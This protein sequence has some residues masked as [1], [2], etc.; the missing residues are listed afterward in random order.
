MDQREGRA[1]GIEWVKCDLTDSVAV[2]GVLREAAPD[3]IIHLAGV[4]QGDDLHAYFAANVAAAGHLL[5]AAAGLAQA[6]RV[7]VVGSAA[8]YGVTSLERVGVDETQPLLAR[9][10]YGLSKT[11]QEKWSL[12]YVVRQL[13]PVVAVRPFNIIGPGQAPSLVPAA[14][15]HQIADVVDGKARDV[16][17]GILS[18]ERDFVDAR[19]VAAALWALMEAGSG[20]DGEVFNIASGEAVKISDMLNACIRLSGRDIVVRQNPLRMRGGDVQT[21]VGDAAKLRRLTGWQPRIPWRQSLADM[22]QAIR[23]RRDAGGN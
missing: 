21:V 20:A 19:D 1:D 2:A 3:G 18:T 9:T 15:L 12:L 6:P 8:Q 11:L 5:A 13:L 4:S 23:N 10:P 14:F 16:S 17:V 22:W 7:L